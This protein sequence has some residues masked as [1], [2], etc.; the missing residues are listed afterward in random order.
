MVGVGRAGVDGHE[1]GARLA[2]QVTVG[3]GAGHHARIGGGEALHVL[4][5][6]H[7]P[8]ALPVQRVGDLAVGAHQGQ[9][10]EGGIAF[11]VTRF[12]AA[13]QAGA[14]AAGPQWLFVRQG[15]QYGVGVGKA[16]QPL[17][18]ADGGED[19]EKLPRLVPRQRVSRAHPH[20]LELLGFVG[21]GLLPLGHACHEEG[22]GKAFGQVAVG[23]PVGQ[24]EHA[25]GRQ[26][27]AVRGA[28]LG[29]RGVAVQRGNVLRVGHLA[30]AGA[31]GM[32]GQ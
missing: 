2:H 7:G 22:H 32:A 6:R 15:G 5:Q 27:Q 14:G 8:L 23:R 28:L 26:P 19:H 20:G 3:A 25:V 29:K 11:H 12:L 30:L 4:E 21:H 13:Q 1:A 16:R 18:G 9:F 31:A 17:Q 24:L 10:A